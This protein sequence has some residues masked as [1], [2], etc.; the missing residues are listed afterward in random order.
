MSTEAMQSVLMV[1]FLKHA[2]GKRDAQDVVAF[3][4]KSN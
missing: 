2:M 3:W 1:E 4:A